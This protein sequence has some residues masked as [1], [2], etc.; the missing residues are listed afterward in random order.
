MGVCLIAQGL[1][2]RMHDFIQ[3]FHLLR[4]PDRFFDPLRGLTHLLR[5]GACRIEG[6]QRDRDGRNRVFRRGEK[7]LRRQKGQA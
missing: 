4:L 2:L 5:D 1:L 3:L 7:S 6:I